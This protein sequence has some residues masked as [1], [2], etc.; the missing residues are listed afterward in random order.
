MICEFFELFDRL[1]VV[2]VWIGFFIMSLW[3]LNTYVLSLRFLIIFSYGLGFIWFPRHLS[4]PSFDMFVFRSMIDG[5][6]FMLCFCMFICR[7]FFIFGGF[8]VRSL[9]RVCFSFVFGCCVFWYDMLDILCVCILI[10]FLFL[11]WFFCWARPLGRARFR[12]MG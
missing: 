8:W 9:V 11:F 5:W 10:S 7:C 1:F 12:F 4:I 2:F 6:V 3:F